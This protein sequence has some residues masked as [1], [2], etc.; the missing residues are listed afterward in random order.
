MN[1]LDR[2]VESTRKRM[3]EQ[4]SKKPLGKIREEAEKKG[5]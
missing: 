5:V 3:A 1:R 2:I 4:E